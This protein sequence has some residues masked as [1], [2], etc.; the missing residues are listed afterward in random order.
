M[1]GTL[2]GVMAAM[3]PI[4]ERM[5][6]LNFPGTS[7]GMVLPV[8]WRVIPAAAR[9][10]D[11]PFSTSNPAFRD[12]RADLVDEN[13]DELVPVALQE[14]SRLAENAFAILGQR[15]PERAEG[16]VR[17]LHRRV[18]VVHRAG[19]RFGQHGVV[20][21]I[22]GL[23]IL[24]VPRGDVSAVDPVIDRAVVPRRR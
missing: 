6:M 18:D 19:R 20:Q 15:R 4:G 5:L 21:R 12:R 2:N 11:K 1:S 13:V 10:N 23:E 24:S 8:T 14:F 16:P 22:P 17:G 7:D 3:T 9:R